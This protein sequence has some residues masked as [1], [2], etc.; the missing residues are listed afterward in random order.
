MALLANGAQTQAQA[1]QHATAEPAAPL[2]QDLHVEVAA[3][4]A[5]AA[6]TAA[7]G[8]AAAERSTDDAATAALPAM[9]WDTL[10]EGESQH[11]DKLAM[12]A[13]MEE[14]SPAERAA[15]LKVHCALR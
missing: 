8:G 11:P 5:A 6:A 13:M 14:L 1:S 9:F 4:S 10:P 12:D 15:N 2:Q 3:S 7:E